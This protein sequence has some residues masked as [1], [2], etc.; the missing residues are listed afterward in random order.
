MYVPSSFAVT[1]VSRL[2]GWI[3]EFSFATLV[4]GGGGLEASHLPLLLE[5]DGGPRG[6]LLGHFARASDH[7]RQAAGQQVLAIFHGPHAY[8]SPRWYDNP[9]LVPTWNYV[10]VH[11]YGRLDLIE[12]VDATLA[13]LRRMTSHYEAAFEPPWQLGADE[14]SLRK[15][16]EQV[17]AFC[18]PID[19][20]EGKA[21]LSQNHPPA[22]RQRVI[23]GLREQGSAA[24]IQIAGLME[25]ATESE[26]S[27]HRQG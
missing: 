9:N 7:W 22:R 13:L 15:L 6:T 3:E 18:I 26:S 4:S 23:S 2:H 17:V 21:K 12:D 8:V 19:R 27:K 10:A 16:A 14:L 5:R 25:L 20:L 11:A 1:D 24:G